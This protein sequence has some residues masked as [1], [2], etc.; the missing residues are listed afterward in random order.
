MDSYFERMQD[1]ARRSNINFRMQFMLLDLIELRARRWQF[2]HPPT[3][4]QV[5]PRDNSKVGVTR[6][7][8]RRGECRGKPTK[9]DDCKK[10]A[11]QPRINPTRIKAN[12]AQAAMTE[13]EAKN[14]VKEDE[15]L[16]AQDIEEAIMALETL[17]SKHRYLLVD[18]L[19][20]ASMEDGN[21]VVVLAEK[22][23][24]VARSRSVIS[25]GGFE[26]GMLPT[27]EMADGWSIDVPKT[28][29]WLARMIHATGLD[30]SRVEEMAGQISVYNE[31]R[32]PPRELLIKEF[33]KVS[34]TRIGRT[35][36]GSTL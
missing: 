31:P 26:R 13:E 8:S 10:L 14:K 7:G 12:N 9:P 18:K 32:V 30:R 21:K 20:N 17:P 27:I 6:G 16:S 15:Y 25:P 4:H 34:S 33:E 1:M 5:S 19:I 2:P 24:S 28:Y 3:A 29:E 22:L 23:F 11:L 36:S 35:K